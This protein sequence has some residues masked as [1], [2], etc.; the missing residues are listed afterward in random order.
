MARYII[1]A[2]IFFVTSCKT[3]EQL[4]K[5]NNEKIDIISFDAVTKSLEF[6]DYEQN[7]LNSIGKQLIYEWYNQQIKTNGFDGSLKVIVTNLDTDVEK[8][9]DYFRVTANISIQF[10]LENNTLSSKKSLNVSASEFSEISGK[11]SILDQE[12]LSANTLKA[13]LK[14]ITIELNNLI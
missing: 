13:T 3:T 7:Q 2:L 9:D 8:K 10:N 14:K 1:I 6:K 12:N 11:F 4:I 5:P